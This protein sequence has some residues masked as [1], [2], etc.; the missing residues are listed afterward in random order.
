MLK[1]RLTVRQ[2][3][4]IF[5]SNVHCSDFIEYIKNKTHFFLYTLLLWLIVYGWHDFLFPNIEA[6]LP[7]PSNWLLNG[8]G[9]ALSVAQLCRLPTPFPS[10]VAPSVVRSSS[11]PSPDHCS[12]FTISSHFLF[13]IFH[14]CFQ[15]GI[16]S[17]LSPRHPT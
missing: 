1:A 14:L 12:G 8:S 7:L 9:S 2:K 3:H 17:F 13:N 4:T 6:W 11:P 16:S 15:T 10:G 5:Y